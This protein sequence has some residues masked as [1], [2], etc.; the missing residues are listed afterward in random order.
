MLFLRGR[1]GLPRARCAESGKNMRD[2]WSRAMKC[3]EMIWS[4]RRPTV[5][6]P[7][8]QPNRH[9]TTHHNLSKGLSW[10]HSP[11]G[12]ATHTGHRVKVQTK[13]VQLNE[14]TREK[15]NYTRATLPD[16]L[17]AHQGC[18]TSHRPWG[19]LKQ[20]EGPSGLTYILPSK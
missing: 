10:F 1:R 4:H 13:V 20:R 19:S 18:L 8:I 15:A 3:D 7:N 17:K 9:S 11:Q 14:S 5:Y 2:V 6:T 12:Q 16:S